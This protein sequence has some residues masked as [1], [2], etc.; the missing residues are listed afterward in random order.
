MCLLFQLFCGLFSF[1]LH[2]FILTIVS[3]HV[4]TTNQIWNPNK[5][6]NAAV[7]SNSSFVVPGDPEVVIFVLMLKNGENKA[8][9]AI[10]F[11]CHWQITSKHYITSNHIYSTFTHTQV[12][13]YLVTKSWLISMS[14]MIDAATIQCSPRRRQIVSVAHCSNL[15]TSSEWQKANSC[16]NHDQA[17]GQLYQ[18]RTEISSKCFFN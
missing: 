14:G 15:K 5:L 1:T 17:H 2:V 6:L 3:C 8:W 18:I 11:S 7:C 4:I 9:L 10:Y 13:H 12:S 16:Q